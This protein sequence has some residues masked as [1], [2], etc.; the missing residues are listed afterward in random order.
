MKNVFAAAW[1]A[2]CCLLPT[3][4]TAETAPSGEQTEIEKHARD[5]A[6]FRNYLGSR[7]P[8]EKD[9][10][11]PLQVSYSRDWIDR[12]PNATGGEQFRCLAEALYFEARGEPVKGQ[13]AVAEVILNRVES[14]Q[15]PN[16]LCGV[17]RQGTGR[18]YQCQFTYTCDG[19]AETISERRAYE[20]VAKV[21]RMVIDGATQNALTDG[22]THYHTTHVNPRWAKVFAETARIGRHIFYRDNS[23]RTAS[24]D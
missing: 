13:F 8:L 3:F 18:K 1:L 4:G 6:P 14:S 9:E 21:A 5:G 10:L 2:S 23:Y 17:I 24:L 16:T 11:E 22:A 15:F 7:K 12:L 19:R 20:R